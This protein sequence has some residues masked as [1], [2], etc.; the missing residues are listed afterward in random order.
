MEIAHLWKVRKVFSKGRQI[1]RYERQKMEERM[2]Q[3]L[4]KS[5]FNE[6]EVCRIGRR[7]TFLR[8]CLNVNIA[9]RT[10]ERRTKFDLN[11]KFWR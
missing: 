8:N 2:E 3:V 4:F 6:A 1:C 11:G 10:N 5:R 7:P 9:T